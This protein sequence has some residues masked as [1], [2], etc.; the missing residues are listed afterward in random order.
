MKSGGGVLIAVHCTISAELVTSCRDSESEFICV[1]LRVGARS[2]FVTCS[3]IPPGSS[4]DIYMD[5]LRLTELVV[6]LMDSSSDI[7]CVGDFNLPYTSWVYENDSNGYLPV[8]SST[9]MSDYWNGIFDLGL[10][11]LN[12]IKNVN[13]RLLDLVF[14]NSNGISLC[15]TSPIVI[16]EDKYHPTLKFILDV[17]IDNSAFVRREKPRTMNFNFARTNFVLLKSFLQNANWNYNGDLV[18][19]MET[20]YD[21]VNSGFS[22]SI[23]YHP[24]SLESG[25]AWFTKELR[26]LRNL[27][28]RMKVKYDSGGSLVYLSKYLVAR[29]KF[30]ILNRKCYSSYISRMGRTLLKDPKR[31]FNFVNSKRKVVGYPRIMKFIDSES[32][33][34]TVISN[35]FANFFR[36]L[37]SPSVNILNYPYNIN[38]TH[39]IPDIILSEDEVLNGLLTLKH[40]NSP[41]PDGVPTAILKL[42]AHELY[43]PLTNMFNHSLSSGN[44]PSVWKS[45]FINPLFKSG[46]RSNIENYRGIAKLSA[47]PKLFEK[48]V[49]NRL[50]HFVGC[51]FSPYQHGFVR[52]RSSTTNLLELTSHIFAAFRAKCQMDVIYT[53]F[54]KAFDT[55]VHNLL[56]YKLDIIGFPSNLLHWVSSYLNGRTQKVRFKGELSST[57]SVTSGVPQGSHLGPLLFVLYLNDLPSIV[58]SSNI[59]MFAD[60]VKLYMPIRDISDS[61]SLQND[62]DNL[63]NWCLANGMSLNQGKCKKLSFCRSIALNFDYFINSYKLESVP[64][65]M[66]LG[67]LLDRKLRFDLHIDSCICKARSLLA[68]IKRWAKEFDDP[69][70]TKRL[71][72]SL[73]RPGLEYACIIWS[74]HN[75]C[76]IDRIESVQKQFLLFALRGLSW[77]IYELPPYE[78]R[79]ML[80]DLP[81]LEKRRYMLSAMFIVKLI[82]GFID[83]N[84]LVSQIDFN[85]PRRLTRYFY[86]IILPIAL[87]NYDYYNPFR[88]ICLIY[89]EIYNT[90]PAS[91]SLNIIKQHLIRNRS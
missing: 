86:P 4:L 56:I 79:L 49:T 25:P 10:H 74:P 37:Y 72:V 81:T 57:I 38:T 68:F 13:N 5:H 3:Y 11:Q 43:I 24:S 12:F 20:F 63:T 14:S 85:V 45:S 29:N 70:I 48:L 66:D 76:Y 67:V 33:D 60:D 87:N 52:G 50:L 44:F 17:Q 77:N 62:L 73:V 1:R 28:N 23:P 61:K 35:M 36:K 22:A 53:D 26:G 69:Y 90:L 65:F 40:S 21:I 7:I 82:R 18:G 15:R 78:N 30:N 55:V 91:D 64:S 54:S 84:F 39:V 8:S 34:D 46:S 47:I 75:A 80:I 51:L 88:R 19:K 9:I 59:L 2:I 41:G 27:R 89:N 32:S 58:D 6:N 83:S 42:C 16:P 71:F 31:F